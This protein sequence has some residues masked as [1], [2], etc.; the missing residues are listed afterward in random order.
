MIEKE[1][2][3][4]KLHRLCIIA[5]IESDNNQ[6][7]RILNA[8]RLSHRMEDHRLVPDMQ[9]G[10]LPGKLFI[11]PVLNKQLTHDI[12][13]QTKCTAAIIE[14]DAV[15]C[16]DRLMNPL[17]LLTMRRLGVGESVAKSLCLTWSTTRHAIKTQYGVSTLT[18]SNTPDAP[19]F[20]PGQGSMTGPTLW[21][22]SFVML[23]EGALEEG[24]EEALKCPI[25]SLSFPSVDQA[26]TLDNVGEAFVDDSNLGCTSSLSLIPHQISAADQNLHS[27]SALSNLQYLA[28][29]WERALFTTGGAINF[30]KSFWFIFHWHWKNGI[31]KLVPPPATFQLCLTEGNN[32]DNP[33]VVPMKSV[34]DTYK[35]LGVHLSPSGDTKVSVRVLLKKAKDYQA[36]IASSNLPREAALLSYYMYL[37]PKLGYSLPAM[38]LPENTCHDI[39]SPTL[40]A[41][42]PQLHL[43]RHVAWSIVFGSHKY[44]GLSL[45]SLYSVQSL[46]QLTLFVGHSRARDKASKLLC[47]SLSYL[48]LVIGSCTSLF[49]LPHRKYSSWLES[50]WLVSLWYFLDKVKLAVILTRQWLPIL[51]RHADIALMDHFIRQ[52]Y[53]AS[54]L[55][56]L[57]CC[58]IYLQVITLTDI[59]SADGTCIIPDFFIG[60][61]LTDRKSTLQWHSQQRPSGNDWALWSSTLQSLQP[62]NRLTTPLGDWLVAEFH[63]TWFWL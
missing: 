29:H 27:A 56:R 9:Y 44:G 30:Q 59:V 40:M 15:G 43:N 26:E 60:L 1:P 10:S 17:L 3:I 45:R 54:Q 34:Y 13:W 37:L 20:G 21:Q 51:P 48:Q 28:Q 5:L 35:T 7:Q 31:A 38:C 39:Q 6:S 12:I 49:A 61:P 25:P 18:Y 22:L 32:M 46:G 42:L 16:Y 52:G 57:N 53:K 58:R 63:Q 14:N 55:I 23:V 36:K 19:L 47:I 50:S 11:T 8:C 2:G 41:V 24:P 33:V 4:P 62:R